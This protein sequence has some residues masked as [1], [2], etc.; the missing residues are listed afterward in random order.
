VKNLITYMV[1]FG[2]SL[3]GA[4]SFLSS[5]FGSD[6][7]AVAGAAS[8]AAGSDAGSGVGSAAGAGSLVAGAG[9][10]VGATS[11]GFA[12]SDIVDGFLRVRRR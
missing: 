9:S 2:S 12:G 8:S 11:S 10:V 4:A 3:A 6:A 7:S 1:V 5:A